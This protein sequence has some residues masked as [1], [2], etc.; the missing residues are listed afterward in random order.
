MKGIN[1]KNA[2][3]RVLIGCACSLAMQAAHAEEKEIPYW[4][5]DYQELYE[6][7]PREA[8]KA[9]FRE[10]KFGMMIHLNTGSLLERG[11]M[12][13][14]P[15]VEGNASDRSIEFVGYTRQEY[16]AA[17]TSKERSNLLFQRYKLEK[18]DADRICALA[19]AAQM[20]YITFT[21][22]HL[23]GCVNFRTTTSKNN[24]LNFFFRE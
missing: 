11:K 7:E 5:S 21:T 6:E 20:K 14:G 15:W 23:G 18:F 2:M 24:S 8:A 19:V 16:E 13:I 3:N 4:L 12:D 1:V 9:W 17:R 10:A 22:V